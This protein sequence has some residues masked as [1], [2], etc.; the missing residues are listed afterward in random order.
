M[1]LVLKGKIIEK[2]GSQWKFAHSLGT[3]EHLISQVVRGKRDLSPEDRKKWAE[4]LGSKEE[5]LFPSN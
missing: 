1:N 2:F 3:H 4:K 5:K